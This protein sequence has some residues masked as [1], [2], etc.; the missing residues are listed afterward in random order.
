MTPSEQLSHAAVPRVTTPALASQ[1]TAKG[2]KIASKVVES[3]GFGSMTGASCQANDY[4]FGHQHESSQSLS[5]VTLS[6]AS[7]AVDILS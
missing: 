2:T 6:P 5:P 4:S 3:K 7:S 1:K